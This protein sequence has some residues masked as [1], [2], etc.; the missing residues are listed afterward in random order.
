M[1]M[2]LRGKQF[3]SGGTKGI[4]EPIFLLF[5]RPLGLT[6][7]ELGHGIH[8]GRRAPVYNAFNYTSA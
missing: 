8:R 6:F 5:I 2:A 7:L 3:H 4:S 1:G